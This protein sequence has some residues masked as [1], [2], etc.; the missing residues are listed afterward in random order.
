MGRLHTIGVLGGMGPE[1][2]VLFMQKMLGAVTPSDDSDHIPLLVDSNSQV[3]SRISAILEGTGDDPA[4]VLVQMA[5]RLAA[6]GAQAL[7]MPCNTAHYYA[8]QIVTAVDVPLLNML[9]LSC[10]Y[11]AEVAGHSARIG[12]LGSPALQQTKV[13]EAPLAGH[14]LGAVYANDQPDVLAAIR[15]IKA[16][17]PTEP[18]RETLVRTVAEMA[19]RGASAIC[20]CCTEFSLL[21]DRI[22]APVPL[23]D[24]LDLLVNA[25]VSFSKEGLDDADPTPNRHVAHRSSATHA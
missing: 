4:P 15:D 7:A 6:S 9:D 20:V 13:F 22:E 14:G 25:C 18:A 2:T 1:A 17:G 3:P 11:G 16:N 24:S 19:E 8:P 5:R 12:L 21:T 10:A 23:F